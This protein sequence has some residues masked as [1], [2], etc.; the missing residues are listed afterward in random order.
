MDNKE[1]NLKTIIILSIFCLTI[2]LIFKK[3]VFIC[4]TLAL[5]IIGATSSKLTSLISTGWHKFSFFIGNFNTKVLLS[6]IYYIIL[7]PLAFLYRL[8]K[9]DSLMLKK[10]ESSI[11]YFS[12]RDYQF[13]KNDFN[14][15]W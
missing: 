2:F 7:T 3:I 14:K 1:K 6:I 12:N 5:L 15:M 9:R 13:T 10:Q 11:S 8:F 4:I